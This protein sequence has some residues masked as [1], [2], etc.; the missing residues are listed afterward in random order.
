MADVTDD[1]GPNGGFVLREGF[2]DRINL[3]YSTHTGL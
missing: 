2:N 3:I 1:A